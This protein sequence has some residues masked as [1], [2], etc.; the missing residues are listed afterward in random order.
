M[1]LCLFR[2]GSSWATFP[3]YSHNG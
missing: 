1:Y 3:V 2:F